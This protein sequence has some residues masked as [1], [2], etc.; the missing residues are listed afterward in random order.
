MATADLAEPASIN[1]VFGGLKT[2]FLLTGNGPDFGHPSVHG[3]Q[4]RSE[5]QALSMS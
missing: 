2:M 1:G 4:G 3:D 5:N